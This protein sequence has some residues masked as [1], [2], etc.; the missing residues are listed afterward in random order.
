MRPMEPING[1]ERRAESH[2]CVA[3][4]GARQKWMS[5]LNGLENVQVNFNF[6][7]IGIMIQNNNTTK[8]SLDFA[9]F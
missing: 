3:G 1:V 4:S 9:T 5:L 2:I 6:M 7:E 8:N